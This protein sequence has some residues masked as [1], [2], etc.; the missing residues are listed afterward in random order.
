MPGGRRNPHEFG[1][2]A[3]DSEVF[4]DVELYSRLRI[5]AAIARGHPT[6]VAVAMSELAV[7]L[8]CWWNQLDKLAKEMVFEDVMAA[9]RGMSTIG[10]ERQVDAGSRLMKSAQRVLKAQKKAAVEKEFKRSTIARKR[11][12]KRGAVDSDEDGDGPLH[13]TELPQDIMDLVF[14]KLYAWDLARAACVSRS[15]RDT[16]RHTLGRYESLRDERR[17]GVQ[18]VE[19]ALD[20]NGIGKANPTELKW[21]HIAA[22]THCASSDGFKFYCLA[23][24]KC[25][26]GVAV[27]QWPCL[28]KIL[29]AIICTGK[30]GVPT[31][32][33]RRSN[34]EVTDL[35]TYSKSMLRHYLTEPTS[36]D[37]DTDSSDD[38]GHFRGFRFWRHN[39]L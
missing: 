14:R 6:E 8:D 39:T 28:R 34:L 17:P 19:E 38:E 2:C 9:A 16:A 36:S 21:E 12:E 30:D 23:Y 5:G 32:R 13:F 27:K 29:P 24:P 10:G 1:G 18:G 7:L 25:L 22:R 26:D 11:L 3:P 31:P 15:W 37:E 33:M 4:V 35:Y 20:H